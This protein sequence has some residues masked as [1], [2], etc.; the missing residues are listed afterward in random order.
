M[1]PKDHTRSNKPGG[2]SP[3]PDQNT[4]DTAPSIQEQLT[5]LTNQMAAF[6]VA[7]Q[8]MKQDSDN[9]FA[10]LEAKIDRNDKKNK[11]KKPE[12]NFSQILLPI[13]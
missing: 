3:P 7:L 10:M 4:S 13:D 8:T 11:G 1:S 2:S 6:A 12:E 5:Q 9:K